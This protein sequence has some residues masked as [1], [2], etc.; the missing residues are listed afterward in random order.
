MD[1]LTLKSNKGA[2]HRK[3]CLG[4]GDGSNGTYSGRGMKGQNAR[5]GGKRRPGFEGG[6]TPFIQK[7]PKLRGFK[8]LDERVFRIINVKDLDVFEDGA[9]VDNKSLSEKK[10]LRSGTK[11]VKILG[12]GELKKK[13]TV[14]VDAFSKSAEEKIT[15]A[16]GSISLKKSAVAEVAKESKVK[17]AKKAEK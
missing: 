1:L 16:G 3:K 8:S 15:K 7:M 10:L 14:I 17:K 5:S 11:L 12:N 6:Q 4:R 9:T 13:L 2:R